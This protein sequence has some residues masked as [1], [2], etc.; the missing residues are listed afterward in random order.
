MTNE[1]NQRGM[2]PLL[3][4]G[5]ATAGTFVVLG[6]ATLAVS[7]LVMTVVRVAVKQRKV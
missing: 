6:G 3:K 4:A 2:K 1:V 7:S 5:A